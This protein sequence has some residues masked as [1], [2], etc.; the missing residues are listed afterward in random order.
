MT[1]DQINTLRQMAA[2]ERKN[3][4]YL[5]EIA[6]AWSELK[7][8]AAGYIDRASLAEKRAEALEA[9]VEWVQWAFE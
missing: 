6:A 9:A 4:A 5:R 2:K 7:G 1:P 3:A 8:Q